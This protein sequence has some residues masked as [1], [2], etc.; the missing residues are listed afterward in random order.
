G[1]ALHDRAFYQL[2]FAQA[3]G[4]G[5]VNA[6]VVHTI[7]HLQN[8]GFSLGAATTL[9]V[10][11]AAC[12]IAFRPAGGVLGDR[13]GRRRL[14][15]AGLCFVAAGLVVFSQ[16]RPDRL[17]LLPIYYLTF[18][19]GQAVWVVLQAATVAAYFATRPLA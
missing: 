8:V 13:M 2:A 17:W 19:F 12:Q 15:I 6:W 14:F 18:A 1:E 9:G 16:L 4:G 10:G 11:F 7:P 3:V 5:A